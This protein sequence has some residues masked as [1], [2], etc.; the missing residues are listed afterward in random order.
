MYSYVGNNPINLT[1]PTGMSYFMG[2]GA[3]DPWIRENAYRVDGFDMSPPGTA[4]NLTDESM[5]SYTPNWFLM[6]EGMPDST[7]QQISNTRD[8]DCNGCLLASGSGNNSNPYIEVIFWKGTTNGGKDVSS[9]LGHVSYVIDGRS[10]SWQMYVN[11]KTGREEWKTD[12]PASLYTDDRRKLSSGVGYI[13]DFGSPAKNRQ[14]AVALLTAY[15]GTGGYHL[16]KNNCAH[17]FQRA[18]N[19]MKLPGVPQNTAIRPSQHEKFL[20]THLW[21]HVTGGTHYKK[22]K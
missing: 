15:R 3:N 22:S 12:R 10:Y 1:D 9:A 16:T 5:L 11:P 2:S 17:A 20:K 21:Q 13:L 4:S 8:G 14:F 19:K 6:N 18:I 7:P